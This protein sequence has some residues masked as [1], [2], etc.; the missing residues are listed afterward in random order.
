L[1]ATVDGNPFEIRGHLGG[2]T[3]DAPIELSVASPAG[4]PV[5]LRETVPYINALPA[6]IR[7]VY[8]RFRPQGRTN[9]NFAIRRL[10]PGAQLQADGALTF[11]GAMFEFD[12]FRY[13]VRNASGRVIVD[14]DPNSG[15]ARLVINDIRGN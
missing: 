12:E 6:E 4:H 15:E 10:A 5:E 1:H 3:L 13:P 7:E 9:L 11:A 8:Y 14:A 2:Y